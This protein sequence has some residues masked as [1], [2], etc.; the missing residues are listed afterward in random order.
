MEG[1]HIKSES[2]QIPHVGQMV[3]VRGRP[4]IIKDIKEFH[5]DKHETSHG[6]QISYIDGYSYPDTDSVIWEREI[7]ARIIA[8]AKLPEITTID[9][10]DDPQLF[11]T[12][13]N[14]YKWT[15]NLRLASLFSNKQSQH[16]LSPW[17][18]SIYLES[19]Q[20]FPLV[21]AFSL[22]RIT[23][24]LADDVGLGKTIEAGLILN[25]LVARGRLRRILIICPA[26]LQIQ[27]RDEMAEKFFL[28]FTIVDRNRHFQLQKEFGVDSNPWIAYPRIITSMDYLRQQD[29]LAGFLG[30]TSAFFNEN[31]STLP[32]DMLIV[33]EAHNVSS[34]YRG[35]ET[36]RLKMMRQITPHFEHRLFLT[37]T[38]HNGYTPSFTGLLELLNPLVFDQVNN[39]EPNDNQFIETYVIRR[40][41]SEFSKEALTR[42]F[43]DRHTFR[44]DH[45]LSN[46]LKFS[47]QEKQLFAALESYKLKAQQIVLTEPPVRRLIVTFLIQLLTKRLLSSVYAFATTW[48]N[49]F[50]GFE[51]EIEESD[52]RFA[53][54]RT[55]DDLIDD[56][57]K[58][59]RDEEAARKIG[60]WLKEHSNQL[61]AEVQRINSIL[62]EL[63]WSKERVSE[64][65]TRHES[66]GQDAKWNILLDWINDKLKSGKAFRTDERVIIF[67]EYKNTL[68]YLL[69][70]FKMLG[71]EPP[72]IET[73]FGGSE[74]KKREAIKEY[75]TDAESPLRILLVTDVASEGL[76]LQNNCRYVIHYEIPWNPMRM[77]QRNGRVDRF[78]QNRDVT[79]LYF[80][81]DEEQDLQFL[82]KV[83]RKVEQ[84]REDLGSVS[85]LFD[86]SLEDYFLGNSSERQQAE[87]LIDKITPALF[88]QPDLKPTTKG[89]EQ[90]YRKIYQQ[91]IA[92]KQA[93]D[94]NPRN[95]AHLLQITFEM[96]AG[97]LAPHPT[98]PMV[99]Q[100]ET[101]PP[102]WK[103]VVTSTLE[104]T[105]GKRAGGFYKL[106][107][108]PQYFETVRGGLR[109]YQERADVKYI[110]LGHPL[111]KRALA[112][113]KRQLWES[114]SRINGNVALARYTIQK[115][116]LPADI[117][118][119]LILYLLIESTNDL[120]EIIHEE[121]ITIPFVVHSGTIEQLTAEL[122]RVVKSIEKTALTSTQLSQWLPKVKDQW[123]E[124]EPMLR[125]LLS[126]EKSR[127]KGEFQTLLEQ[128]LPAQLEIQRKTYSERLAELKDKRSTRFIE[129][130][131]GQLQEQREKLSAPSLF[132]HYNVRQLQIVRELELNLEQIQNESIQYLE[133][134][135]QQEKERLINKVIPRRY[136]LNHCDIYPLGVEFLLDKK[137]LEQ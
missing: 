7:R 8:G 37:A 50:V 33:D 46:K 86:Q 5:S 61:N 21:R 49:H 68:D 123:L 66:F 51:M 115:A 42:R 65:I 38:P 122:W 3:M 100:I 95:M 124:L 127:I 75:F 89:K 104:I 117:E 11:H 39:I 110:S 116:D 60:S 130:L 106:V 129:R 52:V 105:R 9:C 69:A 109:V 94:L 125:Q 107:F 29:V 126:K 80:I 85:A 57:E 62:N 83:V 35:H 137:I 53:I 73:L 121:V 28:D 81:S 119:I 43:T 54:D 77:E 4:A 17:Q 45:Y 10:P 12:F 134:I 114:E 92:D 108:D 71:I 118:E 96:E 44:I 24:L 59:L 26:A 31:D 111:M 34:Q 16:Y 41:K 55:K 30:A 19:Y 136:H 78:G 63:G 103:N 135:L 67:T 72:V 40:L 79:V 88:Q 20:L 101:V 113:L 36:D 22:P 74:Q 23:L 2:V 13:L 131:R 82:E 70:R 25:E 91:L 6:C 48:W 18:G 93:V 128:N 56:V 120:K 133:S 84:I 98:E 132:Q 87:Q 102:K 58:G 112:L 27:W 90:E 47:N 1:P 76:N 97:K 64:D 32:W 99:Y 14:S 15:V